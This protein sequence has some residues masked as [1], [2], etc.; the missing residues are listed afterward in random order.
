ML[1]PGLMLAAAL[2]SVFCMLTFASTPTFGDVRIEVDVRHSRH[3]NLR[4][5]ACA[6]S[7]HCAAASVL[8]KRTRIIVSPFEK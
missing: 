5:R 1:M 3:V 4:D 2:T 8:V 7:D 6:E